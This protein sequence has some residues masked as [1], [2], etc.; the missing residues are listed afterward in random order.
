[1]KKQYAFFFVFVLSDGRI[2]HWDQ[3]SHWGQLENMDEIQTSARKYWRDGEVMRNV[4]AMIHVKV[5]N[6]RVP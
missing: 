2:G 4:Q 6:G 1:M 5:N 3:F